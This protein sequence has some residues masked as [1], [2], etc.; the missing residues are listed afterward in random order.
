MRQP[1]RALHAL[2]AAGAPVTT[3]DILP[4]PRIRQE[5]SAPSACRRSRR[6]LS[7]GADRRR[8]H[9]R[10][11]ARERRVSLEKLDEELGAERDDT[12]P[13]RGARLMGAQQRL[14][15]ALTPCQAAAGY[16]VRMS[17][18]TRY[19]APAPC[20]W[21]LSSAAARRSAPPPRPAPST[22]KPPR[23]CVK[24]RRS[25]RSPLP[26]RAPTSAAQHQRDLPR[27]R[28]GRRADH[29]DL[30]ADR[31][32]RPSSASAPSSPAGRRS[33]PAS[34]STRPVTSS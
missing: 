22:A 20:W 4:D 30:R 10:G 1:Q 16:N 21:R 34:S 18:R 32:G 19:S 12:R 2:R 28:T 3:V 13:Q 6:C 26:D 17:A 15:R 31:A 25:T 29:V 11:A 23:S 8:R 5:L 24:S 33:A 14:N 7:R 9:R 27:R